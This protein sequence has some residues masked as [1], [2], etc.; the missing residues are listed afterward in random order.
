MLGQGT[1]QRHVTTRGYVTRPRH[2]A[3]S[4]HVTSRHDRLRHVTT[5]YVDD[6]LTPEDEANK[7]HQRNNMA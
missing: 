4:R 6:T 3:T 5:G 7:N 2:A 1:R